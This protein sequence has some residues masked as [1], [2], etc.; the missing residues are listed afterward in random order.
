MENVF[1]KVN[2]T[3]HTDIEIRVVVTRGAGARVGKAKWVR[4]VYCMVTDEN[5]IF[6]GEQAVGYTEVEL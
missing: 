4:G 5:H 3:K 6:G 1:V 2:Q